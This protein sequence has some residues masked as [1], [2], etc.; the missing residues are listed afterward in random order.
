MTENLVESDDNSLD[1]ELKTYIGSMDGHAISACTL[2]GPSFV[3]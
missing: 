3:S 1:Y 2:V